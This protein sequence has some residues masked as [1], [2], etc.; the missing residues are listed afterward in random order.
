MAYV[1]FKGNQ[2]ISLRLEDMRAERISRIFQVNADSLFLTDSANVA[3]FPLDSGDFCSLDL[4]DHG[5]YE[6]HGSALQ[7]DALSP[8]VSQRSFAFT[9][10]PSSSPMVNFAVPYRRSSTLRSFQ[11]SIH[12]SEIHDGHLV[13]SRVVVVRFAESEANVPNIMEK[14]KAAMGNEETYVLT[15]AQGN[16]ILQSEGTTGSF[17]WSPN[18]RKVHAVE[19]A[20]FTDWQRSRIQ[21]RRVHEA[22]SLQTLKLQIEEL[23]ESSKGLES[24]SRQIEEIVATVQGAAQ[25]ANLVTV[26]KDTF[27]CPICRGTKNISSQNVLTKT[28]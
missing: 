4:T 8:S 15:N 16:E 28:L 26:L 9:Q 3:V 20:A 21:S 27:M 5:H 19:R 2:R 11:R 17:Y 24:I 14:I 23:L 10:R 7:A 1:L 22:S 12:I 13:S 25:R 6:V 18:S